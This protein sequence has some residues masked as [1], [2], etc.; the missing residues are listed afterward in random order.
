ME[1]DRAGRGVGWGGGDRA[2]RR[3]EGYFLR[4]ATWLERGLFLAA[5]LLLINPGLATDVAGLGLLCAGLASQPLR[6]PEAVVAPTRF[7]S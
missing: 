4:A 1:R 5:A 3:L 6:G 7:A 2:R